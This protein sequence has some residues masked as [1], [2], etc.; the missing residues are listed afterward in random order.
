MVE[1]TYISANEFLQMTLTL[2]MHC[3]VDVDT[4]YKDNDFP[5]MRNS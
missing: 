2:Y 5:S 4:V 1:Y 3:V